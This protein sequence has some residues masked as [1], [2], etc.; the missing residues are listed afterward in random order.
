MF[1]DILII[2]QPKSNHYDQTL[3]LIAFSSFVLSFLKFHSDSTRFAVLCVKAK[4]VM[5]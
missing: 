3:E 4:K 5:V 1:Y 2:T